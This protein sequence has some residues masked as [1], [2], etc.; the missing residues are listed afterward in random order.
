M[1]EEKYYCYK[2]KKELLYDEINFF[3]GDPEGRKVWCDKCWMELQHWL[4]L[5]RMDERIPT[6]LEQAKQELESLEKHKKKFI[7]L[8]AQLKRFIT[9]LE[10]KAPGAIQQF[11]EQ[12]TFEIKEK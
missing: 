7:N 1:I 12:K 6:I 4:Q 3:G 8:I 9:S 10:K 5:K 11:T 2:C